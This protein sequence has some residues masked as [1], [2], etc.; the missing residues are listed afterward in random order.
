MLLARLRNATRKATQCYS[1]LTTLLATLLACKGRRHLQHF[2]LLATRNAT[3]YFQRCSQ[4]YS[5]LATLL[6]TGY[7]QRY[8][9]LDIYYSQRY[10]QLATLQQYCPNPWE[11]LSSREALYGIWELRDK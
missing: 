11:S 6:A 10:S 7:S 2:S 1:L 4:R 9:L 5:V 8:S 3:R